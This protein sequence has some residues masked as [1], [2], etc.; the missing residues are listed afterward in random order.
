MPP[1]PEPSLRPTDVVCIAARPPTST[2]QCRPRGA[3]A[4]ARTRV[5]SGGCASFRREGRA[6][7]DVRS[8]IFRI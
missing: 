6:C 8:P 3:C 4:C 1:C 5:T 2:C 7:L